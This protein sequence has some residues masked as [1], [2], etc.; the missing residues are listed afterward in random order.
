MGAHSLLDQL[1]RE[2]LKVIMIARNDRGFIR[3]IPLLGLLV[4]TPAAYVAIV[5]NNRIVEAA[6]AAIGV[7]SLGLLVAG[8]IAT[9][10]RTKTEIAGLK[11]VIHHK[12]EHITDLDEAGRQSDRI[13]EML[14]NQNST[15]RSDLL[16]Q[17]IYEH[18]SDKSVTA[19]QR[20]TTG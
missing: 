3:F 16:A 11:T 17:S 10:R 7:I 12:D 18:S 5:T 19:P 14:E 13:M 20:E 1:I 8:E 9:L 4:I 2:P 6:T 15:L